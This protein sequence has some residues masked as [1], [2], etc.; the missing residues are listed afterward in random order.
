MD[1]DTHKINNLS[2]ILLFSSKFGNEYTIDYLNK[3]TKTTCYNQIIN[4]IDYV[5]FKGADVN[6]IDI[7]N[8]TPLI[9]ATLSSNK[10]ELIILLDHGADV[11]Y[12]NNYYE[13]TAMDIAYGNN[14]IDIANILVDYNFDL[15]KIDSNNNIP[16]FWKYM[17]LLLNNE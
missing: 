7:H 14:D 1:H 11:N 6:F 10:N 13:I 15:Y 17:E 12:K 16:I 8:N 5:I 2:K 4:I 3:F 9:Y